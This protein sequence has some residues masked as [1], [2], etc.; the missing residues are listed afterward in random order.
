MIGINP[1]GRPRRS[2]SVLNENK[3]KKKTIRIYLKEERNK[4]INKIR[5]RIGKFVFFSPFSLVER[6]IKIKI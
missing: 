1:I 4:S 2:I 5:E 3:K 6:M